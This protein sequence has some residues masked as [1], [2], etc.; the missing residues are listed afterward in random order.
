MDAVVWVADGEVTDGQDYGVR[1][2][3]RLVNCGFSVARR[4]MTSGDGPV[5]A[6]RLHVLSGGSTSVDERAGWMPRGLALVRSLVDAAP[7]EDFTVVGIC[8]GAQMIAEALCPGGVRSAGA[9]AAGLTEVEWEHPEPERLVVASFNYEVI[10]HATVVAGGGD[11]VAGNAHAS[12]QAF[13]HGSQVWGLQF[14][15]ELRPGDVRQLVVHHRRTIEAYGGDVDA[16]LR[17]V[18]ELE[19]R[20]NDALFT[21]LLTRML[22]W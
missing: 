14:H 8:L 5:P 13:R 16:A 12:V 11:V 20:W 6:A 9:I 2:A 19:P 7:R 3:Q 21:R 22:G 10:D 1:L 18:D 4:D 17:S 15:P